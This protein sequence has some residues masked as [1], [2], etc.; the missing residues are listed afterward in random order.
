MILCFKKTEIVLM[1]DVTLVAVIVNFSVCLATCFCLLVFFLSCG[2]IKNLSDAVRHLNTGAWLLIFT[3]QHQL[4]VLD[5][6]VKA[7]KTGQIKAGY[8]GI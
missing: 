2:F 8:V 1:R 7:P 4:A 3:A 6:T 5:D